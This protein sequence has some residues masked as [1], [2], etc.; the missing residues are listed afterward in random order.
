MITLEPNT[1]FDLR[2]RLILKLGSGGYSDVW[3]AEDT[4]SG[5]MQVA[6]KV[7]APG[8][9]VDQSGLELFSKEYSIV[10]NLNHTHLLKPTYFDDFEGMPYLVMQY[11]SA[12]NAQSRCGM[13]NEIDLAH[14][15][16]QIGGALAYLHSQNPPLVHQDIKPNNILIDA[17]G[18]MLLSDFGISTRIRKTLTRS[19]GNHSQS[20]GTT[21]YMAPERFSKKLDERAPIMANDIF[22][23]GVT[24]FEMLTDELPFGELGGMVANTG[25]EA[26]ELPERFSLELR[27]IIAACLAKDPWQ[28]PTA[29]ELNAAASAFINHGKWQLPERSSSK[30]NHED[31]TRKEQK[32][33]RINE[34]K[35]NPYQHAPLVVPK[36]KINKKKPLF[37]M[38]GL[39]GLI[40]LAIVL[41]VVFPISDNTT[42]RD[43]GEMES[44]QKTKPTTQPE[45]DN[46][47]TNNSPKTQTS[48]TGTNT[49]NRDDRTNPDESPQNVNPKKTLKIGDIYAGGIIFYLDKTGEHGLVCAPYDQSKATSWG[50]HH[51]AIGTTSTAIGQGLFNTARIIVTC[52]EE[53]CA[54]RICNDLILN[55]HSDWFLPS[56]D[57]LN[58]MYKNLYLKGKGG[59]TASRYWS[60]SEYAGSES[61][62][63]WKQHFSS[64]NQGYGDKSFKGWVRAVRS[65]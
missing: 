18:N 17:N 36:P 55:G 28:R 58:L 39:L 8:T 11:M 64:G 14:F 30:T 60:S 4:K 25:N 51:T 62:Y 15:I 9:G 21:A 32:T 16:L 20:N 34:A 12:G 40:A 29:T 6:I 65:F 24:L 41:Y 48:N 42:H 10:F 50:C 56:R 44:T 22:S 26:A 47:H 33:N 37:V 35:T 63:A 46:T 43:L 52:K 54:A 57:E 2:Y 38:L 59:F 23:F 1:L 49:P 45:P 7:Y 3:L 27:L 31:S 61:I 19:M 5:N 13:M 53:N